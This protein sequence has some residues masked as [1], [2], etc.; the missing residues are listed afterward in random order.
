MYTLLHQN[1]AE[2][3]NEP[4]CGESQG[5]LSYIFFESQEQLRDSVVLKFG[6]VHY[7]ADKG[8]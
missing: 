4:D 7:K 8:G 5:F 3:S 6:G 2:L 1:R